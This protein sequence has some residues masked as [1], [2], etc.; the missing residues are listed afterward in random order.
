MPL[1]TTFNLP[2]P[3]HCRI[4]AAVLV[5]AL[6]ADALSA[7]TTPAVKKQTE[8]KSYVVA[9]IG[10]VNFRE[11]LDPWKLASLSLGRTTSSGSLIARLNYANRFKISG[12]QMEADAY[13]RINSTTYAYL[14][15]GYSQSD[16]F[17]AWRFG[18]ELF[19][20]LPNAW[21][22]SLGFR[23]LRFSG[24]PVTLYTGAVGKYVGDYWVSVRPYLHF[25]PSG[26]SASAGV[27]ARRYFADGD[28]YVGLRASY[29]SGAS[30]A[31][32]PDQLSRKSSYSLGV[33]GSGGPWLR[34]VGTWSVAFDHEQ[35]SPQNIRRSWTGT[36]GMKFKF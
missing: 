21:E 18:G 9:D 31:I 5:T 3:R 32:T 11:D 8:V 6:S 24:T 13:P 27:T 17:P 4:L 28:H 36:A 22:A 10:Y 34:R 33:H 14:N 7:Q 20:S 12:I 30:D 16:I 23:Q 35:F 29:G 1:P 2:H 15:V 19:K 26:T 25:E